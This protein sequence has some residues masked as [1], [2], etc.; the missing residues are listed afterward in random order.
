MKSRYNLDLRVF[1][2]PVR[3]PKTLEEAEKNR[4]PRELTLEPKYRVICGR[5]FDMCRKLA[6]D[7]AEKV[8]K[9]IVRSVSIGSDGISVVVYSDDEKPPTGEPVSERILRAGLPKVSW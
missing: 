7:F 9:R 8:L 6:R 2:Q 1:E 3:N 5:N 4:T